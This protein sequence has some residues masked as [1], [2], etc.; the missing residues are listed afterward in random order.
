MPGGHKMTF[1]LKSALVFGIIGAILLAVMYGIDHVEV[2]D[3][4]YP[5]CNWVVGSNC[6]F[7]TVFTLWGYTGLVVICIIGTI[8][9]LAGSFRQQTA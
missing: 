3:Q 1:N 7:H 5:A 8:V 2:I 4:T 6:A 9:C